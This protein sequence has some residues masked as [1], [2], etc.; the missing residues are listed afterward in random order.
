MSFT[1]LVF[2][3]FAA[4]IAFKVFRFGRVGSNGSALSSITRSKNIRTALEVVKPEASKIRAAFNLMS[5]SIRTF[6]VVSVAD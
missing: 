2:P 6:N 1:F 3:D 4:L 5:S